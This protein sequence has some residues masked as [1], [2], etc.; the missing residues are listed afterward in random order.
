MNQKL[1]LNWV[2]C[3]KSQ[4][5]SFQHVDISFVATHGVYVIWYVGNPGAP[6]KVVYVGHGSLAAHIR[7][8]RANAHFSK[9]ARH[10]TLYLTWAAVPAAQREGVARYLAETW[11]PLAGGVETDVTPIAVNSPW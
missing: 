1:H 10:G 9:F 5:C 2:K 11:S 3:Q 7:A 8:L 4:W 6:G